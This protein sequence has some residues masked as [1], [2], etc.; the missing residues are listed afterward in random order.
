MAQAIPRPSGPVVAATGGALALVAV[1]TVLVTNVMVGPAQSGFFETFTGAPTAPQP[2]V[3]AHWD[4]QAMISSGA[5][6]LS[7]ST[8]PTTRAHHGPNCAPPS[9]PLRPF[10]PT[11]NP[12]VKHDVRSF[13]ASVF[14]CAN[15]VMTHVETADYG[16]IVLTPNHLVDFSRGEAVIRWNM[17]TLATSSRDWV[18]VWITPF[19]QNKTLPL[20]ASLPAN[21][22]PPK[23]GV[24]VKIG[25]RGVAIGGV[26]RNHVES[27]VWPNGTL[28]ENYF[29]PDPSRR[30]TFEIRISRTKLKLCMPVDPADNAPPQTICWFDTTLADLGWDKGTVQFGH[31]TYNP[32]K[33]DGTMGMP[34][35]GN[36]WHWDDVSISPSVP[37]TLI[38]GLAVEG[39]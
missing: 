39:N 8:I 28:Y 9:D 23:N 3:A 29:T 2:F 13:G 6:G 18:D 20:E 35:E 36:T 15:H 25:H 1:A 37:F 19:E 22:G 27:T 30:D 7:V 17:S 21:S 16:E 24:Q 10:H 33:G 4:M 14:Q 32:F 5:V 12:L 34:A 38:K 11:T 26:V 31:H